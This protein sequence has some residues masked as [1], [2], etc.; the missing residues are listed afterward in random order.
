MVE[1]NDCKL[2][3]G[4]HFFQV[5]RETPFGAVVR[6]RKTEAHRVSGENG[7]AYAAG[8]G[9]SE[10]P[11]DAV[12]LHEGGAGQFSFPPRARCGARQGAILPAASR[13][14]DPRHGPTTE[15]VS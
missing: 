2:F 8:R 14:Y 11:E 5:F 1:N 4:R 7:D 15:R 6:V 10:E 13:Q 9:A 3:Q 12:V